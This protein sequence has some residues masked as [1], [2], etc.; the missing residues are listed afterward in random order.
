M[1]QR[2]DLGQANAFGEAGDGVVAAMHFHQHRGARA[3]GAVVVGGVGAVGGAHFN[4][5]DARAL[6]DVGNAERAADLDELTARHHDFAPVGQRVQHQ[7]HGGGVVVDD[8]GGL[9]AGQFAQQIVDEVIAVASPARVQVE[10]QIGRRGQ[11]AHHRGH[12]FVGQQRPAQVGVQHGAGQ[13]VDGAQAGLGGLVQRGRHAG[14]HGGGF[15][16]RAHQAARQRALAQGVQVAPQRR[17]HL[18]AAVRV[19][20]GAQGVGVQQT[21]QRRDVR[22]GGHVTAR[23]LLGHAIPRCHATTGG[24]R[25][26]A[27]SR[28]RPPAHPASGWPGHR[29]RAQRTG[30]CLDRRSCDR[31]G[32]GRR[33]RP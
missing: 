17:H 4:Q 30:L 7:Q 1:R 6:H 20:G 10:F 8:G 24:C 11:R 29:P 21:I 3:D 33:F 13:V 26:H 31:C 12:R 2:R 27:N 32:S 23:R 19:Q 16:F 15:Q 28:P 25:W 22:G 14:R 5:L 9:G 18:R